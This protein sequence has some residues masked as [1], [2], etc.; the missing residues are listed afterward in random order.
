MPMLAPHN[1]LFSVVPESGLEGR[2]IGSS[3]LGDGQQSLGIGQGSRA[4]RSAPRL[5]VGVRRYVLRQDK[6]FK[7]QRS[8]YKGGGQKQRVE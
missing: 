8:W 4:T 6:C 3:R 5:K 7:D 2:F 1:E